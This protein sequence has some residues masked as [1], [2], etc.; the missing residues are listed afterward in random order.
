MSHVNAAHAAD[1]KIR[2]EGQDVVIPLTSNEQGLSLMEFA[3]AVGMGVPPAE[4][5]VH[6][7][8]NNDLLDG[9]LVDN[10]ILSINLSRNDAALGIGRIAEGWAGSDSRRGR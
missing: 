3:A 10:A 9:N 8:G 4:S 2:S 7:R 6:S 5:R 1:D